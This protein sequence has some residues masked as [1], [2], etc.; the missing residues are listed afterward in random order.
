MELGK[1]GKL[2]RIVKYWIKLE[3]IGKLYEIR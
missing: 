2:D 3:K 1:I